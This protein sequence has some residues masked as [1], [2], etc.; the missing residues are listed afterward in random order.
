MY[1]ACAHAATGASVINLGD[2]AITQEIVDLLGT[3]GI[4]TVMLRPIPRAITQLST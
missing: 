1:L 2:Y 4:H 3:G